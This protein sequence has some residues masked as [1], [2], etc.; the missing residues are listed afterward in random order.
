M[1]I[2]E[3]IVMV[4]SVHIVGEKCCADCERCSYA[5]KLHRR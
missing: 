2:D 3:D 4:K 5:M 1:R